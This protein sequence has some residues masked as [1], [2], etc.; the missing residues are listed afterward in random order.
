MAKDTQPETSLRRRDLLGGLVATGTVVAVGASCRGE[1]VREPSSTGPLV[2][3]PATLPDGLRS[4]HFV[5]HNTKPLALEA[6]RAALG[7][8]LITPVSRFFVRNNLPRPG[9]HIV[10]HADA[11]TLDI[12]GVAQPGSMRLADLKRM[13]PT[14]ITMVLQCSGNGRAFFK[15]APSGSQWATGA[16]ACV[17]WTGVRVADV[18]AARGGAVDKTRYL[19]A[20]G[21]E[22]LPADVERDLVVVERSVPLAKGIDDCILAWELNGEPIPISHGGPLRLIV[23]G[24][25]G[26]NNIKYVRTLAATQEQSSA[27]IQAK[28]YRFRPIGEKG[29]PDQPSMW[30]MPVKSWFN[31]PGADG[32]SLPP[33]RHTFHGVAFS[34]E[35]GVRSVEVSTDGDA[36]V[37]AKLTTPDLGRDAWRTFHVPLDLVEGRHTIYCRATDTRGDTQPDARPEN[38]R[39]YGHNGWRDHGLQVFVSAAARPHTAPGESAGTSAAPLATQPTPVDL[40]ESARAGREV[41]VDGTSPSCGACHT[42]ADA[43]TIGAIG[44]NLNE[45]QPTAE[46]VSRAVRDGV[47]I[48]PSMGDVL[49]EAQ[50]RDVAAYVVEATTN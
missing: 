44:P 27:K 34:G 32:E 47:G 38:E 41:F 24:Y 12:I 1:D 48:M 22:P 49:S 25:F 16:A 40:S 2:E 3:T 45:L 7:A 10:E 19:T 37:V 15:H 11:W 14:T 13:V 5:V 42:L 46:Q 6:R 35:R 17:M 29:A 43:E 18:L 9:D 28:G 36:W 50:L 4:N 31:G 23:P 8:G 30:R 20:T 21:G 39:G 33:G 26:C